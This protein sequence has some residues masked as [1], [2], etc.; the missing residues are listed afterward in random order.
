MCIRDRSWDES[1]SRWV[2]ETDRGDRMK[3]QFVAMANGPLNRPKLPGISG[4]S[5]FKG[6]TFHT[7][8]WDYEYTGGDNSGNLTG[9]N[10]KK[11]AIIGTGATAIQC[12]PHLGASSEQLYVFQRTPSSVDYRNNRE[13]DPAWAESLEPGWQYRRMDNFN[14]LVAG[15][16]QEEDL[17][18]D[19]W[20]DIFRNLTGTAAKLAGRK[21]G[22]RITGREKG[23]LM[24]MA[25]YQ[26]MNSIRDRVDQVVED[27]ATA[28]ALKPWYR[29]F[30][31]RPCFHD[32]Y[33]PTFNLPNVTLVDTEGRGVERITEKGIVA[34]GVEYEV[35]CIVFATG[36]EV[37]TGYTRRAGYDI[38]GRNGQL[39]S[40]KWENGP[41][42]LHGMQ[43]ADFPNCFFMGFTHTAVTVNVPQALNEQAMHI[44]Y[45]ISEVRDQ[46]GS[47]IEATDEGEQM[48][49]DE[50]LDKSKLGERF[51]A[52]C[53]P[54]Y[55]NNEGKA[56]NPD[57]FFTTSYGAGP[58]RFHRILSEWRNDG[59][60]EGA[61]IS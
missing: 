61:E 13:T 21:L 45:M 14:T 41:R 33:L 31:K 25:D 28:E 59:R 34:G 15:G 40:E 35:D 3:A 19:G 12:I 5:D 23:Y 18:S 54:G 7:S 52:E 48:W 9:L 8:R 50:M 11:V 44:S 42:T 22:R 47:V 36:F 17:V 46:G 55:Y 58:I 26:K 32:E 2:I 38:L 51:R 60:L 43:T 29:Q 39:L 4:L 24:K 49:V 20:T 1:I 27:P 30:C 37:G 56:G 6:H 57:G 16:D 53:T 10:D